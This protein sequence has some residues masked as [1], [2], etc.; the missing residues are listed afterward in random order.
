MCRNLRQSRLLYVKYVVGSMLVSPTR[1]SLTIKLLLFVSTFFV[2]LKLENLWKQ[3][4]FTFFAFYPPCFAVSCKKFSVAIDFLKENHHNI[5][6]SAKKV[7]FF[8]TVKVWYFCSTSCLLHGCIFIQFSGTCRF[9]STCCI[10]PLTA[11]LS[12]WYLL[13][14]ALWVWGGQLSNYAN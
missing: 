3:F 2:K 5:I 7:L 9:W 13:A 1:P 8:K 6:K 10:S 4:L 11:V 12:S 14:R